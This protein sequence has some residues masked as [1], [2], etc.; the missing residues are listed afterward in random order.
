MSTPG[1]RGRGNQHAG[2]RGQRGNTW[3]NGTGEP[4][5]H[6]ERRCLEQ[7][8][9]GENLEER[10]GSPETPILHSSLE[11]AWLQ[12]VFPDDAIPPRDRRR[13]ERRPE[14]EKKK[15]EVISQREKET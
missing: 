11:G 2:R 1:G 15:E 8:N 13:A 12:Q 6:R 3:P 4:G 5:P 14:R 7:L 10:Q 9:P